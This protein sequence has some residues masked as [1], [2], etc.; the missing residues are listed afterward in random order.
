MFS[1]IRTIKNRRRKDSHPAFDEIRQSCMVELG[2]KGFEASVYL[3]RGGV[4][5][6]LSD[7]K[8][9]SLAKIAHLPIIEFDFNYPGTPPL[10]HLSF[11]P[12][13]GL[14]FYQS[15]LASFSLLEQFNLQNLHLNGVQAS[16]FESLSVHDLIELSIKRTKVDSLNF[17]KDSSIESLFLSHTTINDQ[18]LKFLKGKPI[19]KIDLFKCPV[20]KLNDINQEYLEE[21]IICGTQVEDLS[22]LSESPV[23][24]LEM[25]ATKITSLSPLS[26]CP[27]EKLHLPG[28]KISCLKAVSHCPISELN[29]IGLE[30]QDLSPLL[31]MP[32][33]R[34]GISR[35][36]LKDDQ[37]KILKQLDL[38]NLYSANDPVDQ[39]PIDFFKKIVDEKNLK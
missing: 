31:Q 2:Q 36:S 5:V 17:L 7:K 21:I 26:K 32:L 12:L 19:R 20:S 29:L 25:R 4:G 8:H 35:S 24:I 9:P 39:K 23:R 11:F 10:T 3:L 27:L 6:Q 14:K 33:R 28:S 34:L 18:E 13:T 30:I 16:D 15:D 38:K 22:P 37:I 1:G